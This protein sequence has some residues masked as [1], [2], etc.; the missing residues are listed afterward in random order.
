MKVGDG[1][2]GTG[3][4]WEHGGDHTI[5]PAPLSFPGHQETAAGGLTSKE[6]RSPQTLA[7]IGEDVVK[8]PSP[9]AED[10]REPEAK[11]NS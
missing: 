11:G 7:P 8:T 5:Q 1:H 2:Q 9:A 4:E 6:E 10:A 3:P